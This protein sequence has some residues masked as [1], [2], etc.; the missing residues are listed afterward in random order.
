LQIGLLKLKPMGAWVRCSGGRL[1]YAGRIH[2]GPFSAWI[3]TEEGRA[4]VE[5]TASAIRFGIFGKRRAAARRL[6]RPLAAAARDGAVVR[7][8]DVEMNAYLSRVGELAFA[9]GLPRGSI[10]LR[11]LVIVPN[12][13][14]NGAAYGCLKK[15]LGAEPLFAALEGGNTLKEFFISTLVRE[16]EAAVVRAA[17]ALNHPFEVGDDWVVVGIN[18]EFAWHVPLFGERAW[19]GHHY[20]LEVTRDP[21][22]RGMRKAVSAKIEALERSLETLTRLERNEI[23]RRAVNSIRPN[24]RGAS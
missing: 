13:L 19:Q 11:R 4:L 21:M 8:V 5:E 10:E 3:K 7:A 16:T 17:P 23:L 15:L 18:S 1:A 20:V 12:L 2:R 14:V 24:W 6:W 22:T 9:E